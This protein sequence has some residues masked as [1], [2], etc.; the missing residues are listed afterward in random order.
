LPIAQ[1]KVG[2]AFIGRQERDMWIGIAIVVVA[3]LAVALVVR[4]FVRSSKWQNAVDEA[5]SR[6]ME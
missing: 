1:E 4:R 5:V 3:L 2:E 6:G